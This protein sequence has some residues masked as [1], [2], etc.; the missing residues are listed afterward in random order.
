MGPVLHMGVPDAVRRA[1]LR[2]IDLLGG[3]EEFLEYGL[4]LRHREVLEDPPAVVVDEDD[5][6]AP[7]ELGPYQE[8]VRVVQE[9]E[10]A[11]E[12]HRR[13]AAMRHSERRGERP[14]YSIGAAVEKDAY[15]P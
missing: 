7:L 10:V 13:E 12:K 9:G 14:V 2:K 8:P 5:R 11:R 4:E 3:R 1:K 15:P 6:E